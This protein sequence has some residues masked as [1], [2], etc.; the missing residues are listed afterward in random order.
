MALPAELN[1]VKALIKRFSAAQANYEMFRSLHQDAYDFVAPQRETFR[2]HSPG[3]EKNNHVFDSTAISA[4]EKFVSRIKASSMPAWKEWVNFTAGTDVPEDQEAQFAEGLEE[5]T[6][7]VFNELNHSNFDTEINPSLVDLVIGT[8]AIIVDQGDFNSGDTFRFT[9]V[10]LAECYPEKAQLGRIRSAWRKYNVTIA[11]IPILWPGA[12]VPAKLTRKAEA[13]PFAEEEIL[14]GQIYNIKDGLYYNVIIHEPTK[15]IMFDQKF[16]EQRFIVFRWHVVPGEVFGRGIGIQM[17]P[18]IRTLNKIVEFD[19]QGMAL[20]VGGL[21]T[22]IDDGI[23]NPHTVRLQPKTII[24]VG[25]NN[26]QNPTLRT[27]EV[28][29]NPVLIDVRIRDYREKIDA[30]FFAN[31]LGDVT[32]PVRSATENMIRQQEMLKQA[33]A[34]FGRLRSELINPLLQACTGILKDLGRFPKLNIDGKQIAIK[35][36]SPLA[37]SEDLEDVQ[38]TQVFLSTAAELLGEE[39]LAAT[40]KVEEVPRYLADKLGVSPKLV[41]SKEEQQQLAQAAQEAQAQMMEQE[42]QQQQQ[43][44]G[45]API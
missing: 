24:P 10:P 14:N 18:D 12:K 27:L 43:Q 28:G 22:G 30:A 23:F 8:G 34:S 15:T 26:N 33:G 40:V 41:R 1:D 9:N 13:N 31:P 6:K 32:D 16:N 21:F 29:G 44:P 38:N 45:G 3:Q 42:A 39:A 4:A 17:L 5:G 37:K 11:E 19:L 2:F 20:N 35:H 25:S 36:T 7:L